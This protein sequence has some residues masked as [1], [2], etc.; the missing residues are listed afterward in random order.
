MKP[1][2]AIKILRERIGLINQDGSDTA[3][4][5]E[6]H[7]ALESAVKA[8]EKQIPMTPNNMRTILDF[9]GRYYTKKGNCPACN[10]EGLYKA[11]IY[12]NKCGQKLDWNEKDG[13]QH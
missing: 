2:E 7:E 1:E 11:D 13:V 12:C 5:V 10:S 3:D 8:L 4:L 9:S 6:Y